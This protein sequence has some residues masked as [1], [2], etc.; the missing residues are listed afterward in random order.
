MPPS[1]HPPETPSRTAGL[2]IVIPA[3]GRVADLLVLLQS[4]HTHGAASVAAHVA[5][6]TVTDD[7]PSADCAARIAERFPSVRYVHGPA[8]GPAANRNHGARQGRAPWILF[9]DDDCYTEDDLVGAYAARLAR[10]PQA[11]AVEGAIGPVGPRPNGNH[12]APLNLDGGCLWSCNMLLRREVFE[13]A[14]GFDER[15]PFACME[16]VDLRERLRAMGVPMV[17]APEAR[18]RHPWRSVSERELS[19]QV[20]SH[21]IYAAKHDD[22]VRTWTLRHALRMCR[23]RLRLYL[24]GG[25]ARIPPGRWGIVAFDL[26]GP[27]V[28]LAVTRLPGLRARVDRRHRNPLPARP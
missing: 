12:H 7:R 18:V 16:D 15:F 26:A 19:R 1:L 3:A 9:L 21:A 22:F 20:I 11:G 24:A 8:R 27:F 23:A 10:H 14:G 17:F 25:P 13:R 28:L 4:L 5:S 6:I 2:D